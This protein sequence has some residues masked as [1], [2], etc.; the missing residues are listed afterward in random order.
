MRLHDILTEDEL[1]EI[2]WKK[3]ISTAAAAGALALGGQG[4]QAQN[5]DYKNSA[6]H[7]DLT[8][9]SNKL[10]QNKAA[11]AN[12]IKGTLI[13]AATMDFLKSL[14]NAREN[15]K[16]KNG[17]EEIYKSGEWQVY[18]ADTGLGPLTVVYGSGK[19]S[20]LIDNSSSA[21]AATFEETAPGIVQKGRLTIDVNKK[22]FKTN[23][24]FGTGENSTL[25]LVNSSQDQK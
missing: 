4:A 1:N 22:L 10:D 20:V 3:G 23:P 2:N 9:I 17:A 6:I 14:G 15:E 25:R 12:A 7:R 8:N 21:L 11:N 13:T 18:K 19:F 5:F 16:F 24:M